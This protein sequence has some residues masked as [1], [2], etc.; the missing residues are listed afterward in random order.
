MP[1]GILTDNLMVVLGGFAGSILG[2]RLSEKTKLNMNQL[3]A[4]IS[5]AIG[6][7]LIVKVSALGAM[8]LSLVGGFIIGNA[9]KLEQHVNSFFSRLSIKLTKKS[10]PSAQYM[11]MFSTLLVL[12][13]CSGT[14]WF[15][16]I[17]EGLTGDSS[18]IL[19]K[20]ILDFFT[21]AIFA[22]V[23]GRFTALIAIPQAVIFLTLFACAKI[24]MPLVTVTMMQDFSAVGGVISLI[25]GFRILKLVE[26]EV[27]NI[28]P[29]LLLVFPISQFWQWMLLHL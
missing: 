15:G 14:G 23:L 24:I 13:C 18:T 19:C 6:V 27:I 28:L 7:S 25:I 21:V 2:A 16:S 8:A 4:F 10:A 22:T 26:V 11:A 3:F 9:L 12:C 5:M 20:A 1:I 29:A 17:N